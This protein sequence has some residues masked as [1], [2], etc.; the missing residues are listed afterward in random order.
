MQAEISA[1]VE[2][3]LLKVLSQGA[4]MMDTADAAV[5]FKAWAA[6]GFALDQLP[7]S[8]QDLQVSRLLL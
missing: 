1:A 7:A 8:L 5:D 4:V 6:T 2:A 3:Q